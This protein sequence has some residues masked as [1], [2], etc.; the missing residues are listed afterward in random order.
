MRVGI[1][2]PGRVRQLVE[3]L[4]RREVTTAEL[5]ELESYFDQIY[6]HAGSLSIRFEATL[7]LLRLRLLKELMNEDV[8]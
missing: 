7:A 4:K 8:E 6:A 3:R 5:G 1:R 2:F